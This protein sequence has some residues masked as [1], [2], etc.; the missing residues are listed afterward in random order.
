MNEQKPGEKSDFSPIASESVGDAIPD[1]IPGDMAQLVRGRLPGTIRRAV[2]WVSGIVRRDS[3]REDVL[4]DQEPKPAEASP[5][6]ATGSQPKAALDWFSGLFTASAAPVPGGQ[7]GSSQV[8]DQGE[9]PPR[10]FGPS[11]IIQAGA[12]Q[13]GAAGTVAVDAVRSGVVAALVAGIRSVSNER[14][15]DEVI[16]WFV[17]S[18]EILAAGSP[19]KETARDLYQSV[20]TLRFAKILGN[21]VATSVSN[22]RGSNLPLSLKVALPATAIGAAFFGMKGA[23]LV[24]LGH[25]IG[26]PVVLLLFLGTAGVTAVVEAFI[27]DRNVRDPLTR[28]LLTFVAFETARRAK[29]ELLDAMRADAMVPKRADIPDDAE[30]ILAVLMEMDPVEFERHVMSFLETAGHPTGLTARSND[31]GVDGYVFH[32]DGV[33]VVQCKRYRADNAVGRPDIQQFKGVIEEQR[34][35][36]GYF[37]TTSR[38]TA[39]A[40]ESAEKSD[41]VH[42]ID[43]AELVRWH[44]EGFRLG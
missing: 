19:V 18:R 16:R 41:R 39:E 5:E 29:K 23:G 6:I 27:K 30:K 7:D 34:A 10:H 43:G 13:V 24:A 37:V 4:T 20:D 12:S 40:I 25:G 15:R 32:P 44:K 42:L 33:V 2:R 14:D 35:Y 8:A 36:R 11:S 3:N 17:N 1:P 9:A 28:L 31:F 38:F 22:Y 21:T 26:L